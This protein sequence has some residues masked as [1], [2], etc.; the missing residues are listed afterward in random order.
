M[1]PHVNRG[2]RDILLVAGEQIGGMIHALFGQY[3]A[4]ESLSGEKNHQEKPT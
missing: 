1:H 3:A 2:R 4:Q